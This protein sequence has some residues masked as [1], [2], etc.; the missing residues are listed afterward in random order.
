MRHFFEKEEE[1][2]RSDKALKA[3][4]FQT[5]PLSRLKHLPQVESRVSRSDLNSRYS[6]SIFSITLLFCIDDVDDDSK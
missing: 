2:R 6:F 5:L 1:Q 3:S 4:G